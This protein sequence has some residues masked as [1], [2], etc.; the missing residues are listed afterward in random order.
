[1]TP[2]NPRRI[3]ILGPTG[4]GKTTLSRQIGECLKLPVIQ[5]DALFHR[6]NWTPTPRDE[7][8][9]KVRNALAAA[10]DGWVFE[11]NYLSTARYTTLPVA[12]TVLWLRLPIRVTFWRMFWRTIRGLITREELYNTNRESWRMTFMSKDSL[13]LWGITQHKPTHEKIEAALRDNEHNATVIQLRSAREVSE[14]V[15]ELPC[16]SD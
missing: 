8:R 12:D 3:I 7:F 16:A 4:S 15:S 1:M 5:L 6:P 10:T 14:F 2:E 13:F 9:E 11:G